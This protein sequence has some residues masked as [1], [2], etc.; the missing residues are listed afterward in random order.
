MPLVDHIE[1]IRRD[2]K[3]DAYPNEMAVYQGVVSKLLQALEWD[4]HNHRVVVLRGS[5]DGAAQ[6]TLQPPDMQPQLLILAA[7]VG[8]ADEDETQLFNRASANPDAPAALVTDGK[9]WRFY[10]LNGGEPEES[11]AYALDLVNEP[12]DHAASRFRRYLHYRAVASGSALNALNEDLEAAQRNR[13]AKEAI[14]K[15]WNA[16]VEEQDY[17]LFE[18]ISERAEELSDRK[19]SNEQIAAFLK[20]LHRD[21]PTEIREADLHNESQSRSQL[22]PKRKK[23]RAP[24]RLKITFLDDGKTIDH[25]VAT[26]TFE[27]AI[28]VIGIE[29]VE[30]LNMNLHGHQLI[31]TR[32]LSIVR[33]RQHGRYY[34][35][36]NSNTEKK[37]EVLD[38]IANELGIALKVEVV[39]KEL[40]Q[41]MRRQTE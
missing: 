11:T 25:H 18:R 26:D 22:K 19:P 9:T 13:A 4:V 37:K 7:Q 20:E 15:A 3:E 39:P 34:I 41:N 12:I 23:A 35:T 30:K 14:P 8:K 31:T 21:P 28:A 29:R 38:E 40:R 32:P 33:Q 6:A 5:V 16:L 36:T 24:D 2:L 27:D 17:F 1:E 10:V